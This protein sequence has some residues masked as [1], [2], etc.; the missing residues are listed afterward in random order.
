MSE[1]KVD[2]NKADEIVDDTISQLI[3]KYG[4]ELT[5]N[6]WLYII[7]MIRDKMF[8][9]LLQDMLINNHRSNKDVYL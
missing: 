3:E 5:I 7:N 2:Y 1:K 9:M 8:I 6:E 4:H